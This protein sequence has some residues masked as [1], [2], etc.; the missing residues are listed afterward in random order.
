MNLHDIQ[1][2][3]VRIQELL[4]TK[5][6][7]MSYEVNTYVTEL[8]KS[9]HESLVMAETILHAVA[10]LQNENNRLK[11]AAGGTLVAPVPAGGQYTLSEVLSCFSD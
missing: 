10:T 4:K 1:Q 2:M 7:F 6:K 11:Q 5:P 9:T 8:E 3:K